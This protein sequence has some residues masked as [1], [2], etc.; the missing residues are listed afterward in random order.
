MCKSSREDLALG[1]DPPD[2]AALRATWVRLHGPASGGLGVGLPA[3]EAAHGLDASWLV[4]GVCGSTAIEI[5]QI[6][7]FLRS[8]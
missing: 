8:P 6:T 5:P 3:G 2:V 7:G 1:Q 4:E